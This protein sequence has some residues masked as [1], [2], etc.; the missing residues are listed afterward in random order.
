MNVSTTSTT[1]GVIP[2]PP[3]SPIAACLGRPPALW[4]PEKRP[5]ADNHAT[6]AKRICA[7]CPLREEC[8]RGSVAR[9]E[10]FGI[11]GGAGEQRRRVLARALSEGRYA[12]VAAAHFRR[13]DGREQPT[14][15]YVLG[16]PATSVSITHGKRGAYAKGCRCE[17][18]ELAASFGTATGCRP[19]GK[20]TEDAISAP[21]PATAP[22]TA[23]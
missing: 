6:E 5:G 16:I 8:L 23:A 2:N 20:K 15:R 11:W 7:G 18:C 22:P 3:E 14:D 1:M 9:G 12:R 10:R 21:E 4:F 13:M 19:M 17:P